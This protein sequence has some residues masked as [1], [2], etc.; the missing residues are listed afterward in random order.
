M[1]KLKLDLKGFTVK[2]YAALIMREELKFSYG[3]G[4]IKMDS[5]RKSFGTLYRRA[6]TKAN[7]QT[8]LTYVNP[9]MLLLSEGF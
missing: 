6:R 4:A 2:Q 9:S 5:T 1:K 8:I 7:T 3:Q